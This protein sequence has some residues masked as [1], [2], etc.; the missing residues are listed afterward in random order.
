M[1]NY[2]EQQYINTANA[3]VDKIADFAKTNPKVYSLKSPWDLFK[4]G[5]KCDELQPS[6]YQATWALA[7][8]QQLKERGE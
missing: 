7:K 3:L 8:V 4:L 1:N 2:L 5:F 6:L